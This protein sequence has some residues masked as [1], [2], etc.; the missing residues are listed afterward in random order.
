LG[1]S[2]AYLA[3]AVGAFRWVERHL[4]EAGT[5]GDY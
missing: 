2:L 4:L 3:V 1:T 5:A